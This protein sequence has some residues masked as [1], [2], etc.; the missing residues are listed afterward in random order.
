MTGMHDLSAVVGELDVET[1]FQAKLNNTNYQD[2]IPL[3]AQFRP[4]G[5]KHLTHRFNLFR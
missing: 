2:M 4:K 5:Y 1:V 3:P